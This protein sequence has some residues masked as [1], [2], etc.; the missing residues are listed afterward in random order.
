MLVNLVIERLSIDYILTPLYVENLEVKFRLLG[1]GTFYLIYENNV[2]VFIASFIKLYDYWGVN[3]QIKTQLEKEKLYGELALLKSQINPHFLFNTLNNIN[4]LVYKK[5]NKVADSIVTLSKIMRY[6]LY[7]ATSEKVLLEKELDYINDYISLQRL[8]YKS[9]DFIELNITGRNYS[10]F[11]PPL[12]FI[13]FIEN[14]FKHGKKNIEPPAVIIN[15][16]ID[17]QYI[18]F[19]C[20]NKFNIVNNNNSDDSGFGLQ[21]IKKQL[22]LIYKNDYALDIEDSKKIYKVKLIIPY[23]GSRE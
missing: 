19:E 22:D 2:V 7:D 4:S 16:V 21:N 12:L 8:R 17:N 14:A 9:P 5:S 11:I 20:I 15:F 23:E 6:M 13:T 18:N 1:Y 3:Q 10:I